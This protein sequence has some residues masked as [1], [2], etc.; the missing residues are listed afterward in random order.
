[1]P[2]PECWFCLK[3]DTTGESGIPEWPNVMTS[4]DYDDGLSVYELAT[5]TAHSSALK[6]EKHW[7][8][9]ILATSERGSKEEHR[10]LGW[11][12]IED[13]RMSY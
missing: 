1:M 5:S 7:D 9:H 6:K 10:T 4:R 11:L 12:S 3:E 13:R 2:V 8:S